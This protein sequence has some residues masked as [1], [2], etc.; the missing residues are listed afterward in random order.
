MDGNQVPQELVK[1][2]GEAFEIILQEVSHLFNLFNLLL[3]D[4]YD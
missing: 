2:V 3:F 4:L 1:E